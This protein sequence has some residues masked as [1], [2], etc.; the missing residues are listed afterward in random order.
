MTFSARFAPA[1]FTIATLFATGCNQTTLDGVELNHMTGY[2]DD[3]T[4]DDGASGE[5]EGAGED[6]ESGLPFQDTHGALPFCGDAE[7]NEGEECDDGEDNGDNAACTA[8]CTINVCGDGLVFEGV[9]ECDG[10]GDYG[11]GAYC[12]DECQVVAPE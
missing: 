4:G 10:E 5:D 2:A 6:S 3:E 7:V 12:N 8:Q 1:L 11:P 9:E